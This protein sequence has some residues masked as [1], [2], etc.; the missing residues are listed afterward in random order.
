[1]T[2]GGA[3]Y[4]YHYNGHGDVV[5]L[6]NSSG[7][8]V[9]TYSYDPWGNI[10]NSSEQVENPYRYAGYRY[11]SETGLYYLQAR[12]YKADIYRFLTQDPDGGDVREPL[13]LN[14]YLYCGD[15]PVN[16][17]DPDGQHLVGVVVAVLIVAYGIYFIYSEYYSLQCETERSLKVL[18]A[19]KQR[20]LRKRAQQKIAKRRQEFIRRW[21][22]YPKLRRKYHNNIQ[23]YLELEFEKAGIRAVR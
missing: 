3:T 1:M 2:R 7:Q 9:N 21:N 14:C 15:N 22:R 19:Q 13:T 11:D 6:T 18:K 20:E 17:V 5:A 10:L 23:A 16:F 8:V 4:Y 12:Y